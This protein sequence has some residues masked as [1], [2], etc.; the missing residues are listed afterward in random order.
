MTEKEAMVDMLIKCAKIYIDVPKKKRGGQSCGTIT[1]PTT[2]EIEDLELK[3][4]VGLHK[5]NY[6]NKETAIEMMILMLNKIVK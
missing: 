2:I 3:L 1:Y 5:A 6:K 4:S